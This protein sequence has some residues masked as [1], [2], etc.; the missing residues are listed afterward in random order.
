MGRKRL[1]EHFERVRMGAANG[2]RREISEDFKYDK[3]KLKY[4]KRVLHNVNVALGTLVSA[5]NEFS[6]IKGPQIS[7]DGLLGGLGYIMPIKEIKE[8][9][10]DEIRKLSDIADCLADELTN[11]KWEAEDDKDVKKLLKEKE[12]IED[13]VEEEI[14]E[15]G[16]EEEDGIAPDDVVTSTDVVK[17]ASDSPVK[18]GKKELDAL[19]NA[20]RDSLVRFG[21][22]GRKEYNP[23]KEN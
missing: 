18:V 5:H 12:E 11:P 6:R 23:I 14:P 16:D 7:P 21:S 3:K 17:Q 20:V 2:A 10:N 1:T 4:I 15:E 19:S 13:K 8:I 9:L 22:L